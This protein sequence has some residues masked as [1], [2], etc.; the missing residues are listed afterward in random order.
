M[1]LQS[2]L[3]Q[4]DQI[5]EAGD[6]HIDRT[7]ADC[8]HQADLLKSTFVPN[9]LA[10]LQ[11]ASPSNSRLAPSAL[12]LLS[13]SESGGPSVNPLLTDSHLL[14]FIHQLMAPAPEV[15]QQKQPA[16]TEQPEEMQRAT[17]AVKNIV[18]I[19]ASYGGKHLISAGQA[20]QKAAV[21]VL[22]LYCK[23]ERPEQ[24]T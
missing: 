23:E 7:V 4:F 15:Q 20:H 12:P 2:P 22:L 11:S 14:F 5:S 13:S 8:K 1:P 24:L 21:K 17:R 19:G 10:G 9:L 16:G 18:V 6:F 3:N